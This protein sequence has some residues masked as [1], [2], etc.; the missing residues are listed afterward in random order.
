MIT[1]KFVKVKVKIKQLALNAQACFGKIRSLH[2]CSF[3]DLNDLESA[4]IYYTMK[5]EIF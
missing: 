3:V 1:T 5:V 2:F 4:I